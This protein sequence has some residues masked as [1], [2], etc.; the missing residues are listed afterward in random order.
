[1]QAYSV[2]SDTLLPSLSPHPSPP[3]TIA[4]SVNGAL[5]LSTSPSPP[6]IYL[7]DQRHGGNGPVHFCPAD[8]RAPA[9]CAAFQQSAAPEELSYTRFVIG[10]QDGLLVMYRI[11]LPSLQER[12]RTLHKSQ[13]QG[14]RLQP[15]RVGVVKQLHKAAMGGIS[16]VDFIPGYKSR[17]VSIGHD[18]KCRLVDFEGGVKILRTW[19]VSAPA[20]CLSVS[21]N[22][23]TLLEDHERI[24]VDPSNT[25]Q[26]GAGRA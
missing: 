12:H 7:Q 18:G 26:E 6:T 16:A 25:S 23:Q 13:M 21:A 11:F 22:L 17:T 8:A 2:S 14:F 19:H 10:F 1:M 20:T 24:Y 15:T 3:N 5:L 9:S 4:I